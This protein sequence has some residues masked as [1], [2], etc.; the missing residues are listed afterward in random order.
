MDIVVA[1]PHPSTPGYRQ[2][3][4]FGKISTKLTGGIATL[5]RKGRG[6]GENDKSLVATSKNLFCRMGP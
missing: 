2:K 3:C 6:K 4:F 1:T 5:S